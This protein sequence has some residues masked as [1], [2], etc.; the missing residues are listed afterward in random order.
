MMR[1]FLVF[2]TGIAAVAAARPAEGQ[3]NTAAAHR[4]LQHAL[5]ASTYR[6]VRVVFDS[7]QARGVPV[8]PLINRAL[9]GTLHRTAG[10]RIRDAVATLAD[11]LVVAKAALGP[12]AS[13]AE[14]T[15]GANALAVGVPRETL[16]EI[17]TLSPGK[18]VTVP[19]GV[20][21]ELVARKVTVGRASQMVVALLRNGA[22]AA[23]LVSLS[24]EVQHDVNAG[25][26][27][28]DAF[29]I[30]TRGALGKIEQVVGEADGQR[31]S[32][33]VVQTRPLGTTPP[34]RAPRKP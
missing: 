1:S 6:A 31:T 5:D 30:R 10:P 33:G 15:A 32:P 16:S 12:A 24:N 26:D 28:E 11:R 23:Q 27:A 34:A 9:Q 3:V 18:A 21:T 14:I 2:L 20:L 19:L 8:E 22:T 17:R 4:R 29:D 13:D 7:A 25:M